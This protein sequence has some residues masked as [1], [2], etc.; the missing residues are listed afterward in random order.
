MPKCSR[1]SGRTARPAAAV[2]LALALAGAGASGS[3]FAAPAPRAAPAAPAAAAAAPTPGAPGIGDR[4]FPRL[5]NGGYDVQ[6]YYLLL[7]YPSKN[8]KQ[9]IT[10][11]VTITAKAT[12]DLSRFNLDFAGRSVGSVQ[13]NGK[14]ARWT[15]GRGE[16]TITPS[17]ALKTGSTFTVKVDRFTTTPK[18]VRPGVFLGA[19]FFFTPDGSAFAPQPAGAHT[20]FPSNDHPRDKAAFSFGIVVPTGTTAVANGDLLSVGPAAGK[21]RTVWR[22]AQR[23]P[24]ATQLTQ[25]VVGDFTVTQRGTRNGVKVR[26]VTPRRLTRALRPQTYVELSQLDWMRDRVGPYPFSTYGT[27]VVDAPLGFALETQTLPLYDLGLFGDTPAAIRNSIML[28]ELAHQYFGNSVSV[29]SWSD[30][31][32]SEGHA[33]WYELRYAEDKGYLG[34][35]TGIADFDQLMRLL[36]RLG[37]QWRAQDGPVARPPSGA[38]D[39]LFNGNVYYGGALVLYALRQEIGAAAF[40][41]LQREWVT[42]GQGKSLSTDDFIATASRVA[43]RDLRTFLIAWLYGSRTPPMPGHPD[44]TVDPV[45]SSMRAALA[46]GQRSQLPATKDRIARSTP[47]ELH[48]H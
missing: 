46:A 12:Q 40:E 6:S 15:W 28:H 4:L 37:D 32:L 47:A 19:P 29:Y 35:W 17:A 8:W 9:T 48:R 14:A 44:W 34:E 45:P 39:D 21:G 33:S 1:L 20:I 26:D 31:W 30:L 23:E 42:Q 43:G 24:M 11:S 22:Y 10:G 13:V 3:A 18:A 2:T 38:V 41:Q 7:G 16:L 5:G 25:V 36:Y 27:L